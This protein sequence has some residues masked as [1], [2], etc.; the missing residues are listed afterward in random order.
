MYVWFRWLFQVHDHEGVLAR[1]AVAET[2]LQTAGRGSRP[3][4]IDDLHRCK[5]PRTAAAHR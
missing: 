1:G 3:G 2:D 4:F 5:S